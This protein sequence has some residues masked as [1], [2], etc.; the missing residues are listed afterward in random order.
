MA[1]DIWL[2]V[3]RG[4]GPENHSKTSR[5]SSSVGEFSG[6]SLSLGV[7]KTDSNDEK[8][9]EAQGIPGVFPVNVYLW[10]YLILL[11]LFV[12][13]LLCPQKHPVWYQLR[14]LLES[15]LL[16]K[17]SHKVI[18]FPALLCEKIHGNLSPL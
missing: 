5:S 13:T 12:V 4:T 16:L 6:R 18:V 1:P 15:Y 2:S 8:K 10:L 11:V 14:I 3:I 7:G 9:N 17:L